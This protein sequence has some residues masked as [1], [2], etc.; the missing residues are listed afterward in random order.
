MNKRMLIWCEVT[1]RK[2]GRVANACGYYSPQ[3]IKKLKEETKHWEANDENYGIL[4]PDC[5]DEVER[6]KSI[7]TNRNKPHHCALCGDYIEQDNLSVCDKCASEYK[8]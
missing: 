6:S 4:C 3:R 8:F 1:C 5:K 7:I 2:C